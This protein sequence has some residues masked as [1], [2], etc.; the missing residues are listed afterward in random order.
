M[1]KI[2]SGILLFLISF[3]FS[4]KKVIDA[5]II[6]QDNDTLDVKIRVTVNMIDPT[7]IYGSSFNEKINIVDESGKKSKMEA[8]NVKELSFVDFGG[9]KRYF[10]NRSENKKTLQERLFN[11]NTIEWFRDYYA[12]GPGG[13]GAA[14]FLFNKVAKKG[15]GV[16]Y[17][18]GLPKKKLIEFFSDEPEMQSF[19]QEAKTSS[20]RQAENNVDTVMEL[21]LEKYES[22]KSRK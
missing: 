7:L 5:Q 17:F 1:K 3:C 20:L 21:L 14:D 13:E 10:L 8:T 15:I 18:T 2:L 12:S 11:G 4:Q 19:I 9:K 16:A 6:T 22:L